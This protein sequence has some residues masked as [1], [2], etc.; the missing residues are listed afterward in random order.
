MDIIGLCA[1]GDAIQGS[2]LIAAA[3]SEGTV[4]CWDVVTGETVGRP[5]PTGN[6]V[7]GMALV[8]I[9]GHTELITSGDNGTVR[10]WD[11]ISGGACGVI[12]EGISVVAGM[13]DGETILAIGAS[14]GKITIGAIKIGEAGL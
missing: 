5:M 14:D 13:A 3:D 8:D 1:G 4:R 12:T 7:T 9:A 10:R 11:P 6:F 2:P